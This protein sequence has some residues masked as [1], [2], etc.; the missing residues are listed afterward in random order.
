MSRMQAQVQSSVHRHT[1]PIQMV[2]LLFFI[3]HH[4][5]LLASD[6]L[7]SAEERR[8]LSDLIVER[9]KNS[10]NSTRG[11]AI[12]TNAKAAC[13]SCHKIGETGGDIGPALTLIGVKKPGWE[14]V[15]SLLWPNAKIEDEYQPYKLM[16]DDD[17]VLS[18]YLLPTPNPQI[19]RLKDPAKGTIQE[20]PRR[21]IVQESKSMSLMPNGLIN[22]LS[23][24]MQADLVR[25]LLDLGAADGLQ[26]ATI[27]SAIKNAS[28]HEVASFDYSKP[29]LQPDKR[30]WWKHPINKDRLYDYYA[31]QA[32]HFKNS[33]NTATILEEYPGLDGVGF[34]H[35]GGQNEETWK[36]DEWNYAE[37]NLVQ[38]NVLVHPKKTI[39]RAVCFRFGPQL[40][41]AACYDPDRFAFEYVW[42]G[43]FL[44]FS[45]VRHGYMDGVRIAGTEQPLPLNAGPALESLVLPSGSLPKYLG[46]RVCEDQVLFEF[47]VGDTIYVDQL[48]MDEGIP[49][50]TLITA[51]QMPTPS[52]RNG[53]KSRWPRALETNIEY[54][55]GKGY[56][57]DTISL[58]TENPWNVQLSCGD[59]AFLSDGTAIVATIQG[60]VFRVDGVSIVNGSAAPNKARWRRIAA[61]IHH[62]LG[63]HVHEDAI[64]VLGRNQI[65][66]LHDVN[67]DQETDWYECFSKAFETSPNGHDYIC[68]LVRDT[69]GNFYTASGNQGIVQISPDGNHASVLATGFRNPDGIGIL[70]DGTLT[71]PASEGDWTAAS[72]VSLVAPTMPNSSRPFYKTGPTPFFGHRGPKAG[73]KVELPLV[74]FPR[75]VDN[76]SGGQC[77]VEDARMGPIQRQI[78][79]TSFG[80][81]TAM[82]LLRDHVGT[83]Q[84]GGVYV[85]P[86]EYR[87]GIHRAKQNPSDGQLYFT[88][89]NGWGTYTPDPGCFQRLRY[90]GDPV[91]VPL[92]FHVRSNGVEVQFSEPLDAE[93]SQNSANHFAQ[94]WNY[95]YSPGYGSKEYSV[96]HPPTIG[97]DRLPITSAIV[98]EDRKSLFLE[99]PSLQL[100]NQLHLHLQVD[101]TNTI[102]LYLT[103]HAMDEPR[104]D[105]PSFATAHEK[106]LLPHPLAR[107]LAWL[108]KSVPNPWQKR[109]AKGREVRIEAMANLQFSTKVIEARAGEELR[110]TLVNP[111][112]VPHNWALVRPGC[113]EKIG[114][115]ANRLVNDPEA[116]LHHYVPKSE[117]VVCYTDVVE[118]KSEYSIFF[119]V[120]TTPGRYPYLCTFPGHW[121][122][123]NGE[124][125]VK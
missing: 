111:D 55:K 123:M 76:S 7:P 50:R 43:G 114:E 56:V 103:V 59:H 12:F 68:G 18:G 94:C 54:G 14:I 113:L 28:H 19:V 66:R 93:A 87:A 2:F 62:A 122:V 91:Q 77:W 58:P 6:G 70:P 102:D 110:L 118:P 30:E 82:L 34:G 105:V 17:S 63:V 38:C 88:G 37:P 23:E 119:K 69:L 86:G 80:T 64:Y 112:V 33:T 35:W 65:T 100:C 60:D 16:L 97:H 24:D 8:R 27:E 73:Q 31:K 125:V 4:G 115:Q 108:Q 107:D 83:Q 79:H 36:G 75:G 20:V 22:G 5:G 25:F 42:K 13:F 9:A 109:L 117:D 46:Y 32:I 92:G 96:L 121:M 98:S 85:L 40:E 47:S 29:P 53:G 84:Q 78:L 124:L 106:T 44:K 26:L 67:G 11:L 45:S 116:Y 81:G 1:T 72:M 89:M 71:V 120:P 21:S 3:L 90:T 51:D 49:V 101:A 41:W 39:A 74:Y 10:G 52:I 95:R 48:R 61:G 57:V 104:Q 15:E 99:I